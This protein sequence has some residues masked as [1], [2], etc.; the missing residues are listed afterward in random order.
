MEENAL[1]LITIRLDP[2][3]YIQPSV[4]QPNSLFNLGQAQ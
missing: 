1:K 3:I 4:H 2:S